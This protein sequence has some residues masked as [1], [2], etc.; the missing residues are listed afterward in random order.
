MGSLQIQIQ[1]I[2]I[3]VA[4]ACAIPGV[5]LVLRRMSLL[6]DA[7]SHSV[8]FGIVISFYLVRT[9]KSPLFIIFASLSGILVYVIVEILKKTKLLKEDA[10]IGLTFPF[11]FSIGVILIS[12]KF[13]N[14]HLDVDAVL[15][16]EIA[17]AP[18][19]YLKVFGINIGAKAIYV[20]GA[21]AVINLIFLAVF[22]KELKITT[23]DPSLA[24]SLGIFPSVINYILMGIT[25]ITCV[26]S[27]DAV[28][29]ILVVSFIITP[30]ASAYLITDRLGKMIFISFLL[31]ILSAVAGYWSARYFNVSISGSMAT[32]SGL[33]FIFCLFFAKDKGLFSNLKRKISQKRD[34]SCAMVL[35]HVS[36]HFKSPEEKS[37]C[38]LNTVHSHLDWDKTFTNTIF[39]TLIKR[40]EI[41]ISDNIIKLT[42]KGEESA[43]KAFNDNNFL[44]RK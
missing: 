4:I 18:F 32:A 14:I 16:G 5:F 22:Y 39:D 15:L 35:M 36:N 21:I 17:F 10:A 1:L 31:G 2:A 33:I 6:S 26:G 25:S 30:P 38:N 7:I 40:Q 41:E 34:F 8:L 27:F 23:F 20:I 12:L 44:Q 9:L 37:E 29:A 19:D 11:L 24:T 13:A 28:G 42:K 43:Q 3:L